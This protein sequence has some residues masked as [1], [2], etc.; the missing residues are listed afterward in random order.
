MTILPKPV[1]F[2]LP[3]SPVPYDTGPEMK[4]LASRCPVTR[5]ELPDGSLAWLVTGFNEV[6][7]VL[8]HQRYSRALAYASDRPRQGFDYIL[9]ESLNAMDP[10]GPVRVRPRPA[11]LARQ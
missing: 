9:A 5:V 1:K 8:I 3:P 2:P 6:R 11:F 7:E 4:T 10:P